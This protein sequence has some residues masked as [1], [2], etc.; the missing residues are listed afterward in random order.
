MLY[1]CSKGGSMLS[2]LV[3]PG[4]SAVAADA[5]R[6]SSYSGMRFSLNNTNETSNNE[7]GMFHRNRSSIHLL[8][9]EIY[10]INCN[11]SLLLYFQLLLLWIKK[12]NV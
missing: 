9:H 7:D 3:F 2:S 11:K 5:I 8:L 4:K 1:R 10:G 6:L 12:R